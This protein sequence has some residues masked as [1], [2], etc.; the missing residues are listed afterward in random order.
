LHWFGPGP[1]HV[2]WVTTKTGNSI[3]GV[4]VDRNR[5]LMVLRAAA[6]GSEDGATKQQMWTRL[7]GDLVI[8]MDNIDFW[9]EGLD[10]S[11]LD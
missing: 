5:E 8:P 3:K 1:A 2:V 4:L 9:Q 7:T 11:A 6:L 10:P